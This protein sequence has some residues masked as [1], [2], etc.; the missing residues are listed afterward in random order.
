MKLGIISDTH[1]HLDNRVHDLFDGVD[2]IIHAGDIGSEDIIIELETIAPVT[3]V[4]GNMDSF[5]RV[6]AYQEFIARIFEGVRF[7]I[8]H[9]IGSPYAIR[10]H[11]LPPI[12][13]YNPQ[14][15]I[16]GHTH[17]PHI[18][19]FNGTLYFN[20][21]SASKGRAGKKPGVG[22]ID[23]INSQPTGKILPLVP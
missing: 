7:F 23:I 19:H 13:R 16:F 15:I 1:G 5:G 11:L 21:G 9:D 3:A 18:T 12:Q 17:K 8:V 20:P 4:R 2:R 10:R 14:V 6:V 22:I